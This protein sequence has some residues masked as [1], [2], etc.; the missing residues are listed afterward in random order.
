MPDKKTKVVDVHYHVISPNLSKKIDSA[1]PVRDILKR[2]QMVTEE[3]QLEIAEKG[4]VDAL[5]FS[6]RTPPYYVGVKQIPPSS[7]HCLTIARAA[8]DYLASVCQ[9][10][11]GRY[12][13]FADIPLAH[14]DAAIVEMRRALKDLGLHGICLQTNYEGKSLDAPEFRT[15]FEEANRLKAVIHLHPIDPRADEEALRDYFMQVILG[16]PYE[17]TLT[18]VRLAYAGVLEKCPDLAFVLSHVGGTIPFIWW[19]INM[20]YI[21]NRPGSHDQIKAPATASLARC[22]N[23]TALSDADSLMLAYKRFGGDHILF[24]TDAPYGTKNAVERTLKEV[25]AMDVPNT[26]KAKIVGGNALALSQ[27][28]RSK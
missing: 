10:Y 13:A 17:T 18:M 22:Y 8:N 16:F 9:R 12:M 24:G 15:F 4:G 26:V 7:P 28:S 6:F 27:R 1:S 21:S 25:E 5:W 3:E 11:P 20:P 23:D 2:E 14:G 19:R